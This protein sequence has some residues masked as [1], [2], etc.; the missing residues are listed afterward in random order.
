MKA[1]QGDNLGF[2]IPV[3]YVKDFL[4]NREA[5]SYDKENPNTGYRYLDPPRRLRAG[6]PPE[7]RPVLSKDKVS[8]SARGGSGSR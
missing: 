6:R 4:R 8:A 5:F 2:A 3:N 1:T 7:V